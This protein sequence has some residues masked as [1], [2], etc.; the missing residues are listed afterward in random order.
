MSITKEILELKD[1]LINS[2]DEEQLMLHEAIV[3]LEAEFNYSE[4]YAEERLRV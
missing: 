2:F 3:A 1:E 4:E